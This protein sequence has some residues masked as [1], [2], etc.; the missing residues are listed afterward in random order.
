MKI[1][2][3]SI[4]PLVIL[5]V[6]AE[7]AWPQSQKQEP[8]RLIHADR[9]R[10]LERQGAT[11]RIVEGR[12]A[13]RQGDSR[14]TCDRAVWYVDEGRSVF[15]GNVV[16]ETEETVLKAVEVTY[17]DSV[18]TTLATGDVYLVDDENILRADTLWYYEDADSA[19]ASGS[20]VMSDSTKRMLLSGE[21]GEYIRGRDIVRML[22]QPVY[23]QRDSLGSEELRIIAD[24]MEIYDRGA[25]SRAA[26]HVVITKDST[27]AHCG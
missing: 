24:E 10:S 23:I 2:V 4:V 21:R 22:Q 17:Y 25:R 12:V 20:V 8:L 14:M 1:P 26:G 6:A 15:R 11:V 16:V 7:A 18:R 3:W 13:F 5:I 9:L 19:L 27:T